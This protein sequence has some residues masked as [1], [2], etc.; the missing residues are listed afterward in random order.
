MFLP[1]LIQF[2]AAVLAVRLL[3]RVAKTAEYKGFLRLLVNRESLFLCM[4]FVVGD[5][6]RL[7]SATAIMVFAHPLLA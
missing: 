7:A 4:K 6:V 1:S 2:K 3:G 5:T